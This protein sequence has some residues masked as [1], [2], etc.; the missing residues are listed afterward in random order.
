VIQAIGGSVFLELHLWDISQSPRR[1][2][3]VRPVSKCFSTTMGR[4]NHIASLPGG[5][6]L[7]C[8]KEMRM[9]DGCTLEVSII[10]SLPYEVR[11]ITSSLGY[12]PQMLI[13]DRHGWEGLCLLLEGGG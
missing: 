3:N 12:L 10:S 5:R 6:F 11:R 1:I 13:P 7:G 9:G 8:Q 4:T 2:K